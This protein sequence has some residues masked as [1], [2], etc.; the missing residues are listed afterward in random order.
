[1][2]RCRNS[3]KNLVIEIIP[4]PSFIDKLTANFH[5]LYIIR[6]RPFEIKSDRSKP[7]FAGMPCWRERKPRVGVHHSRNITIIRKIRKGVPYVS[8][9]K[10]RLSILSIIYF[11]DSFST[12]SYGSSVLVSTFTPSIRSR[13]VLHATIPSSFESN[14]RDVMDGTLLSRTI[15]L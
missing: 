9:H 11:V 4:S 10:V 6:Q 5:R 15:L 3:E 2:V 8:S 12:T 1:M 7:E 14:S 13:S